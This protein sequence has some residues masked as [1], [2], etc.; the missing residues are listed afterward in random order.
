LNR[1]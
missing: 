1:V